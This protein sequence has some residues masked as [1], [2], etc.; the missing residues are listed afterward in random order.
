MA[1]ATAGSAVAAPADR[2]VPVRQHSALSF[3]TIG[4]RLAPASAARAQE[5]TDVIFDADGTRQE[6]LTTGSG[7]CVYLDQVYNYEDQAV[8]NHVVYGDNGEVYFFNLIPNGGT[9][10][11]V[12]GQKEGDKVTLTL[13]Q[14]LMVHPSGAYAVNLDILKYG[15]QTY[16]PT[17]DKNSVTFTVAEDGTMTMD[18]LGS[19]YTL[20]YIYTDDNSFAGYSAFELTIAPFNE[21]VAEIPADAEVEQWGLVTG[22]SGFL[23]DVAIDGDDIYFG[24]MFAEALPDAV[25]KGTI[26][27]ENGKSQVKVDNRQFLGLDYDSPCYLYFMTEGIDTEEEYE[28]PEFMADDYV[29]V[30]DYDVAEKML[31]PVDEEIMWVAGLSDEYYYGI[32][33]IRRIRLHYQDSFAGT[34]SAPYGLYYLTTDFGKNGFIFYI[35]AV[36][37]TVTV[38][39]PDYLYYRLY[40]NGELF[41]FSAD[42]Y[43]LDEDMDLIPYDFGNDNI[44]NYGGATRWVWL[45]E[46]GIETLGVQS[47]YKYEG[48]VTEST[49]TT[50]TVGSG[51]A[52]AVADKEVASESYFDLSG[53]Q[54]SAPAEGFYIVKRT[55]TDG[56]V[57][58][59]KIIRK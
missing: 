5:L 39:D 26:V 51:V 6:T 50:L 15:K 53:R 45:F 11:Y 57:T 38:L 46:G 49:I 48:T 8:C 47:V 28:E 37:T 54:V 33:E 25:I 43:E 7:T 36:S 3:D 34:P 9:D 52:N 1:A 10:T 32:D 30:F 19:D 35:P 24:G 55:Y 56:S 4:K 17:D 2:Q 22:Q 27:T 40:V 41:T 31:T 21:T 59:S 20:G 12:K 44:E 13:P 14:T 29:F 18:D 58:T 16:S 42:L 23:V